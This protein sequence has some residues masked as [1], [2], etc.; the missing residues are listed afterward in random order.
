MT[1]TQKLLLGIAAVIGF[2]VLVNIIQSANEVYQEGYVDEIERIEAEAEPPPPPPTPEERAAGYITRVEQAREDVR[3]FSSEGRRSTP[4]GLRGVLGDINALARTVADASGYTLTSEQQAQ[5]DA[6]KREISALQRR[7]FPRLRN[8][9]GPAARRLLW[10]NDMEARTLGTGY[11]TVTFTGGVFAA[12]R[13]I[14]QF[15]EATIESLREY[16]F[17]QARYEWY[18]NAREWTYYDIKSPDDGTVGVWVGS[19]FREL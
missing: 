9:Y 19:S 17:K 18:K 6:L 11:R 7:E 13:N 15:H 1:P 10:E 14:Q 16:R 3:A 8:D 4:D 2:L 12:N 5:V